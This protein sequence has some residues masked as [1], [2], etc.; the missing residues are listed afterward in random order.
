MALFLQKP[1]FWNIRNYEQPS[2]V[3]AT[4]GF[5]KDHGFGHEEWNNSP[6]LRLL[7]RNKGYRAFHTEEVGNAPVDSN[8]VQS[9]I[10]M[11]ASHDGVQ[12]LVGVAANAVSL[13]S[14][15]HRR[16]AIIKALGLDDLCAEAWA[17]PRIGRCPS[18]TRIRIGSPVLVGD[19]FVIVGFSARVLQHRISLGSDRCLLAF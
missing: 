19:F 18:S 14:S 16:E 15:R 5:P 6:R 3:R 13:L 11:T 7:D 10:F 2:G 1:V 17:A 4:S 8:F 12:Q 9:F